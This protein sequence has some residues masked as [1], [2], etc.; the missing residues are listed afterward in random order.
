MNIITFRIILFVLLYHNHKGGLTNVLD[1]V[2][3]IVYMIK[4]F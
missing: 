2:L 1:G 3:C 4:A